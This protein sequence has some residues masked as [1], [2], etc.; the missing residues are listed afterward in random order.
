MLAIKTDGAV[1]AWGSNQRGEIGN[2]TVGGYTDLPAQV[3]FPDL[4]DFPIYLPV[5][6]KTRLAGGS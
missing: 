6:L 5:I 3:I 2:N 4:A 1:W